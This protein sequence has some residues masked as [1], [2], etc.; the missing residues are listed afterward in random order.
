MT[1]PYRYKAF[2]SYAHADRK[3]AAW[4][5]RRIERFRTP[6]GLV[7]ADGRWGEVAARLTP[8]FRD[9]EELPTMSALGEA[10]LAA[11]KESEFLIVLCSPAAARSRWVNEEIRAFRALNGAARVLSIIAEGDPAAAVGEGQSGCFPPA[12]LAPEAEGGPPVEPIAADL[13]GD[14]DGDRL[15]FLKLAAGLLGVGLDDL[16][17]REARRRQRVQAAITALS[18]S[19]A[20]V[21]AATT[22]FA[23]EQRKEAERQRSIAED[24]RDT[25]AAALDYLAGIFE[26]ANPAT[27]NPKTITAL[28]VLDRGRRR[29]EETFADKPAVQAKLL[30]VMGEVYAN[31]G[32]G[33]TARA[34]LEAAIAKPGGSLEDRLDALFRLADLETKSV[35][36]GA[37]AE[38][39]DKA[40]GALAAEGAALPP[41]RLALYEGRLAERRGDIDWYAARDE[42]ALGHYGAAKARYA[43]AGEEGRVFL[44]RAASTRGIILA[45]NKR[46]AEA[47]AELRE[48]QAMQIAL[49]GP[50]HL[51]TAVADHN[52]AYMHFEAGALESAV[53]ELNRAIAVYRRV[54]EPDHPTASTAILLLGRILEKKGDRAAAVEAH[55]ESVRTAKA[56]YGPDN[57]N[58]GFR[59]LYL[60]KAEADA[61]RPEEGLQSLAAAQAIYDARFPAGDFNHGD[62]LVYRAVVLDRAGRRGEARAACAEGL[63]ILARNLAAQDPYLAEMRAWCAP[64]R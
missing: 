3:T 29:I 44:A 20:L 2:L 55:R 54:L 28:T 35:K 53:E 18:S 33:E 12:L 52:L 45:R 61:G 23:V 60:A 50:D 32:E 10:L 51:E 64:V 36:T 15:A 59:L 4:L 21:L 9:R 1:G 19:V 6:Q 13:R 30:G 49:H 42:S 16:V 37:A 63:A 22:L 62:I 48:A 34:T 56:A 46:F 8:V 26:I 5:F 40:A 57:E 58:V 43:A 39:L 27:E 11:L 25:A 38:T 24:E 17:H 41:A 7:G 47:E 14:G 31:L